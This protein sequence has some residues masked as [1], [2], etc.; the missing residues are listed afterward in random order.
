MA[1]P[2]KPTKAPPQTTL[3][4]KLDEMLATLP[5]EDIGILLEVFSRRAERLAQER[6]P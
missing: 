2:I 3:R 6:Q 4:Q 5:S 1:P